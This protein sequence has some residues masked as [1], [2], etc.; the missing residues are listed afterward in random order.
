MVDIVEAEAAFDAKPA[1]VGGTITALDAADAPTCDGVG[2][3]AANT[4]IGADAVNLFS[5]TRRL[6]RQQRACRTGL[7]AFAT[8]DASRVPHGIGHVE[9]DAGA[10]TASR[11]ADDVVDLNLA[12]GA[13]TAGAV[14]TGVEI[15]C[16]G[17]VA[18]VGR[19]C[20]ADRKAAFHDTHD[21][22]PSG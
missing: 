14:N 3:L 10:G 5:L 13:H 4:A 7:N 15:D 8:G 20:V 2:H 11:H 18:V 9:D 6:R 16:Y 21:V 17:R 19:R 22:G 12:A 1:F